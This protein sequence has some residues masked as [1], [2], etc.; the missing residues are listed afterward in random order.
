MPTPPAA[1][2]EAVEFARKRIERAEQRLDDAA[3]EKR[4]GTTALEIAEAR[5][6]AWRQD[7]PEPQMEL[8]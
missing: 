5:L 6:A 1:I 7:N 2:T 4:L 3:R 8:I